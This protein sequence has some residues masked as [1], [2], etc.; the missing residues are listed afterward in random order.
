MVNKHDLLKRKDSKLISYE[1]QYILYNSY[2]ITINE[3]FMMT[4]INAF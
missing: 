1:I 2:R 3:A 4:I